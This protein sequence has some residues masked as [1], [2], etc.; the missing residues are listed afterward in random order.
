MVKR[1]MKNCFHCQKQCYGYKCKSCQGIN[2]YGVGRMS[3]T[4]CQSKASKLPFN[5]L[6][7]KVKSILKEL[8]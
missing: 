3:S 1:N 5:F 8:K 4:H 2:R 7:S 6:F